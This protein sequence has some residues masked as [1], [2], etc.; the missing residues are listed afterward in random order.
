MSGNSRIVWGQ[1]N[2]TPAPLSTQPVRPRRVLPPTPT[3]DQLGRDLTAQARQGRFDQLIVR[4]D[5]VRDICRVLLRSRKANPVLVGDAGVGKTALV[6]M[7]ARHLVQDPQPERLQDLRLVELPIAM[8]VAGTSLRG[9]LEERLLAV[10][11][12]L[13]AR[14][15]IILFID[16]F[17]M[18]GG[19]AAEQAI[20]N[21]L[22]PALARDEIR[23][24][25]ATTPGEFDRAI[26][27]DPALTRRIMPIQIA[28]PS[29]AETL[30]LLRHLTPALATRHQVS[31]EPAALEAAV[32][33]S[34]AYERTRKL[35]DKA[36]DL[37]DDACTHALLPDEWDPDADPD[38][39][40][41]VTAHLV[42]AAI[43]N[44]TG[45]PIDHLTRQAGD[46]PP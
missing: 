43:A 7:L 46:G 34:I 11:M 13:K 1:T 27:P 39:L 20:V 26:R 9:S 35:P 32:S 28:E 25:G 40:P 29:A 2:E 42:A 18:L 15:D 30:E 4:D 22:K 6:E 12:E 38:G 19:G 33:L 8:V 24:I 37:L 21:I 5:V 10:L 45:I 31:I 44:R 16:E 41:V 14:P 3:L 36:V 23:V 17:H